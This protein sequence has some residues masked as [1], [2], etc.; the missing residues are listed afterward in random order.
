[1][2]GDDASSLWEDELTSKTKEHLANKLCGPAVETWDRQLDDFLARVDV[3]EDWIG[4]TLEEVRAQLSRMKPGSSVGPDG[5][6]VS[7]LRAIADHEQL[8]GDLVGVIKYTV[9]HAAIPEH[10]HHSLLALLAKIDVPNG[11]GDLRPIAM[12]SALQKLASRLVMD[13]TFPILRKGTDICCSGKRRLAAD[14]VGCF[15]RLREVAKEWHLPLL[16]AKLDIK[17]ACDSLARHALAKFLVTQLQHCAVGCELRYLLQQLRPNLLTGR[18]PVGE[19]LDLWCT[20]RIR[21]GS[22]ESA[23]LFALILQD[24]LEN[25]MGDPAWQNFGQAIPDLDVELLMYQDDLF[26]WFAKRLELIDVCLQDLGLQLAASKTAITCTSDYVGARHIAFQRNRIQV[27]PSDEPIRVLGLHFSFDGDQTRQAK[28]LIARMRAAFWEHRD[29]LRG[30]ASW[31]NKLFALR[32]VVEEQ[33]SWVAGAV[34]WS[35]QDLSSLNSLQLH[36]LRDIFRVH[37][38]P[39]ENWV[40]FNQRS[41]RFVRAWMHN[42]GCERWSTRVRELQFG[43]RGTGAA[44][45]KMT[46]RRQGCACKTGA[47]STFS[48]MEEPRLVA[49]TTTAL[50]TCWGATAPWQVLSGQP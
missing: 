7:L 29:L 12:S 50:A 2:V 6:G 46:A 9:Q 44:K 10:W 36:I 24:A 31:H 11:P 41:L 22:P 37:R 35:P 39:D 16:V 42:H 48:Q 17:G 14:L 33:I 5:I 15:T 4:F 32:M 1:M 47:A 45:L 49:G 27:Q 8:S 30:R 3:A 21:Q 43:S 28:E 18:V 13:R 26:P 34:Y 20:T 40:D 25:M 23:K 38:C 19:Q